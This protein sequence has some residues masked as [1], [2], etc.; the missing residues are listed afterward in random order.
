M[1]ADDQGTVI[2]WDLFRPLRGRDLATKMANAHE[3]FKSDARDPA[4]LA[5]LREW[6]AYCGRELP[7]QVLAKGSG[8]AP[9]VSESAG[10][11]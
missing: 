4:A 5:T 1:S 2:V 3:R 10:S 6:Y 9:G 7:A 11:R 8:A